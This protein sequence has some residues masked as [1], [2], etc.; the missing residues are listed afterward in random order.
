MKKLLL[1]ASLFLISFILK[2]QNCNEI[3]C[4]ANPNIL[5]DGL[6]ICYVDSDT[7]QS[8]CYSEVELET[9]NKVC[10]LTEFTYTTNYH[11]GSNFLWTVIGGQLT[12]VSPSGNTVTILWDSVG[13]GSISVTEQD[14]LMCNKSSTICINIIPKP[15]PNIIILTNSD[16]ICY[17]SPVY[18][19]GVDLNNS[20]ITQIF[21]D[22]SCSNWQNNFDSTQFAY[23]L[24]YFWDFGD[25]NFSVDHNPVHVFDN[26]GSYSVSLTISNSCQC[27]DM[28]TTDIVVIN[29][30][31]PSIITCVGPLCEGDTSEYCTDSGLPNWDVIG[32][33]LYNSLS[34]DSCIAVIWDNQN[35]ELEDGLG[36]L[37]VGDLSSSCGQSQSFYHVPIIP[38]NPVITGNVI[39]CP[40]TKESY[41]FECI[42]GIDYYWSISAGWGATILSGNNTSEILVAFDQGVSNTSFQITLYMS[43]TTLANTPAPVIVNIDVLPPI[44]G[45]IYPFDV[46]ENSTVNYYDW[47]GSQYNWT[48]INGSTTSLLPNSQIDVSWDQGSGNGMIIVEP[49][50]SGIYCQTSKSFPISIAETPISAVKIVG[51]SLI[52]PGSTYIYSV[53]E[54]NST[55]SLNVSY[56]WIV[57]G[58]VASITNGETCI[59]TWDSVGPYLISVTNI[60]QSPYC[61][62]PEFIKIINSV[63]ALSPVIS[64]SSYACLNSVST[65]NLT[66]FYPSWAIINWSISNSLLGSVVDGQ[67]SSQVEVEWGNQNGITDIVIDIDVCGITYSQ[68]FSITFLNQQISFSASSNPVCSETPVIFG[69]TGGLGTYFWDF[70]DT[71]SSFQSNPNK[72][73]DDPG[74]YL[75]HLTFTDSVNQCVSTYSSVIDVQGIDGHLLPEGNSL[76][77]S[78]SNIS[79]PLYISTISA[80]TFLIEWFHNGTS[81]ST[82]N[83]YT[84][85]SNPPNQNGIGNYSVV[86]TDSNGCSNTLNTINIDTVNCSSGSGCP[87]LVPLTYT[88]SCNSGQ[89]T[90]SFNF[91][92]PNGNTVLWS[93]DNGSISS[94]LNYLIDF[95]NAGVYN[96]KCQLSGCLLGSEQIT[97]PIVVNTD[98]SA[99]CDPLNGNQ[100]TY[101]FKD[102]SSYLLGYGTPT[103]TWDFGDGTSSNLQ[104]PNHVYASNGTYVVN[105]TVN[106]GTY[107]CNKI[108][109]ITVTDFNVSYSYSGLECENTPTMNFA[110]VSSLT[111]INSWNW[112]FGDG[113]SSARET[114]RRT[115]V[116]SGLFTTSL[117]ITD[118]NGCMATA[119]NPLIIEQNPIINYVNNLGPFCSNDS[120]IDLSSEVSFN[121]TNG[122]IASWSGVGIDYDSITQI[123]FFN[124]MLAGSGGHDISVTVTDNNGCY[125][126]KQIMIDVLC[127]EKPRIFG[128]SEYCYD[129]NNLN[130]ISLSTQYIYNSYQWYK[131]GVGMGLS[132]TS[133]WDNITIGVYDYM[134]EVIDD[135]GCTGFSKPF[136]LNMHV[137][138]N[139]VSLSTNINACPNEEIILSHN[140]NQSGVD[141]YWNTLPQQVASTVTVTAIADYEY[142]VTA[143]NEF[144]CESISWP[145]VVPSEIPL[146]GVLSGCLCDDAI[147]NSSGLIN[148][149][150]LNNSLQYSNYEWLFNNNSFSPSQNASSLIIDPLDANYLS[151]C[152]GSI[153]LEVTDNNGCVSVSDPLYIQPNCNNCFNTN[154]NYN[155]SQTICAGESL[156][157]GANTYSTPG[158]FL[159]SYQSINGCDSNVVLDLTV[160]PLQTSFQNII[161]CE[162]DSVVIGTSVYYEN[163]VYTDTFNVNIGCDSIQITEIVLSDP[164]ANLSFNLSSLNA[165]VIGGTLPYYFEIGNQSGIILTSTNN[166]GTSVSINPITSGMY[167]FFIIDANNCISDTIFMQVDLIPSSFSDFQINNLFIYPNPSSDI[168]N[169]TFKSETLQDLSIRILSIVGAE[170]YRETKNQFIGKYIKQISLDDYGKGIYFLEIETNDGVINKKLILQ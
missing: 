143:I 89:G 127:P 122:E 87:S 101:F 34:S 65:F 16:T 68:V 67:G 157:F 73:Y 78:T 75:V 113:A 44:N 148:I 119:T 61:I 131:N 82:S 154:T 81:L 36:E 130:N 7:M 59:I 51:D 109:V 10:E 53:E 117:Q 43:S 137:S 69:S 160:L 4:I 123:Y 125:D 22:D 83:M 166:F 2:S 92:S 100:I 120:L 132:G 164:L 140:G 139:I 17:E 112:D 24:Q 116:Q 169:I 37:L 151:I 150:G 162:G 94:S 13:S 60:S 88:D 12:S 163:G 39:A 159:T 80:T 56:N 38:L 149:T 31:G 111:N 33:T 158:T 91:S 66:S 45:F 18:F 76:Y 77:C 29:N 141:Y 98:Y 35:N 14:S 40:G 110:S 138:P 103:Y 48:V 58:G 74:N 90:K 114:P 55:S 168:F 104:N 9:C 153:T 32:G 161:I 146:C 147:M 72:S 42:A 6:I 124:P 63:P 84:V 170:V 135:N 54:S 52:C 19:Q 96:V 15:L 57:T 95:N 23:E 128:E 115:Y 156:V 1:F 136:T 62:S 167:Y 133:M 21:N 28:I 3:S 155:I 27:S 47:S 102:I 165:F 145:I 8:N 126:E 25:G 97:V 50:N 142:T 85:N 121:I 93:V 49:I 106:Y 79:Q 118:I 70:G 71:T 105:F 152:S 144:G 134:V 64:G 20:S 26:P 99:I 46:C 11:N 5:Q 107:S 30:P 129:Y 41:S 108:T 86:L